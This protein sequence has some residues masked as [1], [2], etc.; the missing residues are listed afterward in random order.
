MD[1]ESLIIT[2]HAKDRFTERTIKMGA[3]IPPDPET[4]IRKLLT[5]SVADES[6]PDHVRVRRLLNND[7]KHAIY[8]ACEGWRFIIIDGRLLTCERIKSHMN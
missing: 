7:L 8:R 5:R 1:M 4:S 6:L 3:H 2:Q